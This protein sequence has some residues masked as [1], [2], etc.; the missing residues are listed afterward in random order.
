MNL[1]KL[2]RNTTLDQKI[3]QL[4]T[5]MLQREEQFRP[6]VADIKQWIASQEQI[7]QKEVKEQILQMKADK[8]DKD[9]K[10]L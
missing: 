5:F 10:C 6:S 1:K 8:E 9:K 7:S 4:I 2:N 3:L